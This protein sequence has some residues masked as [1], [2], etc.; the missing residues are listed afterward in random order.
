MVRCG[1]Y[2]GRG[3]EMHECRDNG[4]GK[5]VGKSPLFPYSSSYR[6]T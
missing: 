4:L 3:L 5:G 6:S 2:L 1:R